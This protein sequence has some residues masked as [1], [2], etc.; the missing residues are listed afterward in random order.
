LRSD[1]TPSEEGRELRRRFPHLYRELTAKTQ[2][3]AIRSC[4]SSIERAE[5]EASL[6]D[7]NPLPDAV[8][9]IRRCSSVEE[10]DE[11]I[12]FLERRDE[13]SKDYAETLKQQLREHGLASFGS[14]KEWGHYSR[15]GIG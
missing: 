10:A 4:R 5:E 8:D 12:A 9:Y 13:I 11:V 15:R 14:K 1:D 2:S 7:R 3:I 6:D